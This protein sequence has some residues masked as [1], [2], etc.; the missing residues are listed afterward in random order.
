MSNEMIMNFVTLTR[1]LAWGDHDEGS[2]NDCY[3]I[4]TKNISHAK[5]DAEIITIIQEDLLLG[6]T[7]KYIKFRTIWNLM[8]LICH[9]MSS[10]VGQK[11]ILQI[12]LEKLTEEDQLHFPWHYKVTAPGE[13]HRSKIIAYAANEGV[14][15]FFQ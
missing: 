4:Y 5:K 13:T 9:H 8:E 6:E 11:M 15:T 7:S 10:H 1:N 2:F 12:Y 14:V 3:S